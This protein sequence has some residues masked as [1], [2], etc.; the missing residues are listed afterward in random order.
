MTPPDF[1]P[2][3][4][5]AVFEELSRQARG[6]GDGAFESR[7]RRKD[8]T[9][10]PVEVRGRPFWEG[11][12]R[13]IVSLA[14]DI[15]ER[16]GWRR[17]CGRPTPGSTWRSAAPMSASGK[18]TCPTASSPMASWDWINVWEQ[19]RPRAAPDRSPFAISAGFRASR[20]QGSRPRAHSTP[21]SSGETKEYEVEYR[22][23]HKDGTYRWMLT[24][25]TAIRDQAGKPIR[26]HGQPRRH[27]RAE[28]RRGSRSAR[29]R[30]GSASW[31]RRCHRWSGRPGPTAPP[32]T[33]TPA[34]R[35]TR[36][37]RQPRSSGRDWLAV[38]HPDDRDRR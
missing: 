2:D 29:A 37:S 18:S 23:R 17:S 6:R 16:N 3:V 36:A 22:I 27:H 10:F 25:G 14:R 30:R 24:R 28:A 38:L 21:T 9:V 33:S 20:R 4:T 31:P 7:H 34:R 15:T 1:D 5:P 19:T 12:R 8:G 32:T 11:G 26:L 13:F 35:S